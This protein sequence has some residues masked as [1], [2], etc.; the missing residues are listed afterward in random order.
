VIGGSR[1]CLGVVGVD[2]RILPDSSEVKN[3]IVR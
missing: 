2:F 1:C 3:L